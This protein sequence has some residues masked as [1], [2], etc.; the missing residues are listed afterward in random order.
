MN[1]FWIYIQLGLKH[2]LDINGYDHVLFIVALATPFLFNDWKKV[3]LLVSLFTVGHTISLFLSVF[4][5]MTFDVNLIEF[6]IPVT[7]LIT[8]IHNF[9]KVK[10]SKNNN[11][12]IEIILSLFFGLIHGFGFSNYFKIILPGNIN[13][14]LFPLVEFAIGIEVAQVILVLFVLILASM[15]QQFFKVSRRDWIIVLS[16]I[17]IGVIIPIFLERI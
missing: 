8:A 6:L 13:A 10:K 12:F 4:E 15:F 3:L 17:I 2:V 7:I 11:H 1:E 9:F 5:F 14:K 16:S